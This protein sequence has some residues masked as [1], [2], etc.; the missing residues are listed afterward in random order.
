MI[1]LHWAWALDA[2]LVMAYEDTIL[3]HRRI[4]DDR[5]YPEE[6]PGRALPARTDWPGIS[7][8][9]CLLIR[10]GNGL[11]IGWLAACERGAEIAGAGRSVL[12]FIDQM[13]LLA[14]PAPG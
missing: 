4:P 7:W 12:R 3:S 13:Q 5:G 11:F 8:M 14:V 9:D 1:N 2:H 6:T 10:Q